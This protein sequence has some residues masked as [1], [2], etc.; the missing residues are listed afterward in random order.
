VAVDLGAARAAPDRRD[1]LLEA[2]LQAWQASRSVAVAEAIEAVSA[3][4][5]RLLSVDG[6]DPLAW[7]DAAAAADARTRGELLAIWR[8]R[9]P[10]TWRDLDACLVEVERWPDDPRTASACFRLLE[11]ARYRSHP[12][13]EAWTRVFGLLHRMRD[14]RTAA[15]LA[16]LPDPVS[17]GGRFPVDE[18]QAFMTCRLR[19]LTA[20]TFPSDEPDAVDRAWLATLGTP[21]DRTTA[22]LF[23]RVR[24]DPDEAR[25]RILADRLTAEDDVRGE[26]ITLQLIDRPNRAQ[27]KRIAELVQAHGHAWLGPLG[28]ALA[29]E[30]VEYT[31]GFPS[32]GQLK[33]TVPRDV[34]ERLTGHPGWQTFRSLDVRGVM[35]G[36]VALLGH[37]VFYG[38][39]ELT[40]VSGQALEQFVEPAPRRLQRLVLSGDLERTPFADDLLRGHGMPE[41]AT[42]GVWYI[43]ERAPCPP[44]LQRI[45]ESPLGRRLDR[46]ELFRTSEAADVI[47]DTVAALVEEGALH[48]GIQSVRVTCG[49]GFRHASGFGWEL[50]R[51]GAV[52]RAA[53][54]YRHRA[55]LGGCFGRL[56][57]LV[58]RLEGRVAALELKTPR[59]TPDPGGVARLRS[60]CV[61]HGVALT[62]S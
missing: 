57:Q 60:T 40:R 32:A 31:W 45:L 30:G 27:K 43:T 59:Y 20:V 50:E 25:L 3:G 22:E 55:R 21:P 1:G 61:T 12:A 16:R 39:E 58:P 5:P 11:E 24:A 38:L 47:P 41:L 56:V 19:D 4:L 15:V 13:R 8:T 10:A 46:L 44:G 9:P 2:L 33:P 17:F 34:F 7:V 37:P 26:L 51:A 54:E 18:T 52:W 42:L 14:P 23:A 53:V 48:E 6:S 62:L 36:Y 35:P 29:R 49:S 28:A